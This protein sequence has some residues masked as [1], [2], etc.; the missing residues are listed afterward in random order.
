M[1]DTSSLSCLCDAEGLPRNHKELR[2]STALHPGTL[3]VFLVD[4]GNDLLRTK[5]THELLILLLVSGSIPTWKSK[6]H[7]SGGSAA[8]EPIAIQ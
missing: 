2:V 1:P 8:D 5:A 7:I 4:D 6:P 3:V